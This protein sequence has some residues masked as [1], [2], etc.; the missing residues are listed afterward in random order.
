MENRKQMTLFLLLPD[1]LICKP[2]SEGM[3][4][5][6]LVWPFYFRV[7]V[8]NNQINSNILRKPVQAIVFP[9]NISYPKTF[10]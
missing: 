6:F 10:I 7:R 1:F 2:A 5:H 9:G 4:E 3:L 8:E